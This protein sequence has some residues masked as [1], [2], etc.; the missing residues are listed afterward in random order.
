MKTIVSGNLTSEPENTSF[1]NR[2]FKY[3]D[4]IFETMLWNNGR[5]LFFDWHYERLE[6]SMKFMKFDFYSS[7]NKSILNDNIKALIESNNIASSARIRLTIFRNSEGFY[8]PAQNEIS[9]HIECHP[10][11]HPPYTNQ[12]DGLKV[13]F[14]EEVAL[15]CNPLSNHKTTAKT[16]R[17]LASLFA[18]E[19]SFDNCLFFNTKGNISEAIQ[20]NIFLVKSN[21]L[22]TPSLDQ[23][24]VDGIM[25]RKIK[26]LCSSLSI[27][28]VEKPITKDA[29][30]D[31]DELFLTNVIQGIQWIER[32][33]YK[34]F[35]S[36]FS[37]YLQSVLRAELDK[38]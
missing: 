4:A 18:K 22:I 31:S 8:Q 33:E 21:K 12:I 9:Y 35:N 17:V 7:L 25:R 3:S 15:A 10:L 11:N 2:A 6:K 29:L 1:N 16:E 27:D 19:H 5:I 37:N 32:I 24:C 30:L 28:F 36:D 14:F 20:S 34:S 23:G 38:N 26:H 13:G